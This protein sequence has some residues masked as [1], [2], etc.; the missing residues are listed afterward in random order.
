MAGP[1][2]PGRPEPA[3][4]PATAPGSQE[5]NDLPGLQVGGAGEIGRYQA[6]ANPDTLI[7]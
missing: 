7:F 1:A 2:T 5:S 6:C 4:R 3:S